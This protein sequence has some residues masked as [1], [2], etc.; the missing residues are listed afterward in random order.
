M[1]RDIWHYTIC[2]QYNKKKFEGII[3]PNANIGY[4]M[5]MTNPE[6]DKIKNPT[7]PKHLHYYPIEIERVTYL[8]DSEDIDALPIKV[9]KST[10]IAYK[11]RV[12]HRIDE[13]SSVKLTDAK[14]M[15]YRTFINK[16]LP[17]EHSSSEEFI[18]W[19]ILS[20]V[21]IRDKVFVRAISY[22]S[23]G[24]TSTFYVQNELMNNIE[25]IDGGTFAKL[26]HSLALKPKV[27]VLDEV[28]DV[29]NDER[30]FL[31]KVIRSCGDGRGKVNNDS[32]AVNGTAEVFDLSETSLVALYNFPTKE[33]MSFFE[34]N[35]HEKILDR[36][37]PILLNG[38]GPNDSPLK[39]KHQK[40]I[41]P[42]TPEEVQELNKFARTGLYY[43]QAFNDELGNAGKWQCKFSVGRKR[44]QQIYDSICRG[45]RM[46]ANTE[47]EF[48]SLEAVLYQ[49]HQ[50]YLAYKKQHDDGNIFWVSEWDQNPQKPGQNK[51]VYDESDLL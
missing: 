30:R 10:K 2:E 16:M 50:N 45:L 1:M 49:M 14:E 51:L 37:F 48:H 40:I 24:K 27:L 44:W 23:W 25:I 19:K 12:Y 8:L 15:D 42:I 28:D 47:E 26:K 33:K 22:P 36:M 7:V 5:A 21:A 39:Q 6:Y 41:E 32:R 38:G 34:N 20:E 3:H 43:Q 9:L 31:A 18:V 4:E 29:S 13:A 35:F 17:Y 46:Y 11:G